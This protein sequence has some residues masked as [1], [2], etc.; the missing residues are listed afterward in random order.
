[1][2]LDGR[3]KVATFKSYADSLRSFV[4]EAGSVMQD[5]SDP[6]AF[7]SALQNSGKFGINPGNGARVPTYVDRVA[8]TIRGLR[9][10]VAR[11]LP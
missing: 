6:V 8:A 3:V 11:R 10:I 2:T 1:M 9:S 7:A 5:Q 4:Q